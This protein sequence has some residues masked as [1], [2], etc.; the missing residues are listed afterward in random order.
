MMII[1]VFINKWYK[2]DNQIVYELSFM[3]NKMEAVIFHE[4][5]NTEEGKRE[6][7]EKCGYF[8]GNRIHN[9]I[10]IYNQ[11]RAI[12]LNNINLNKGVGTFIYYAINEKI[13]YMRKPNGI[14]FSNT[15]RFLFDIYFKQLVAKLLDLKCFCIDGIFNCE[16]YDKVSNIYKIKWIN[17]EIDHGVIPLINEEIVNSLV[18]KFVL[19]SQ[20]K[21]PIE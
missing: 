17:K 15:N 3:E 14:N 19:I 4:F 10:P 20:R 5:P 9:S 8:Y 1:W 2:I 12:N 11:Y 16:H 18:I 7:R 13:C 21:E 6:C